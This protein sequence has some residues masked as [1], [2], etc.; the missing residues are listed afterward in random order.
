FKVVDGRSLQRPNEMVLGR[1]AADSYKLTVGDTL[2]LYENRYKIV[3]IYET[4]S[5]FEDAGGALHIREAQNLLS[6]PRSVSFIFVDV[7]DPRQ[8]DT[9]VDAINRRFPEARAT[10]ASEFAQNTNDMQ[11]SAAMMA[12]IRMLAIF[13]GGIVVANTM[14][15][16]I[17]ERTREIGTL[18]AVGW[19]GRRIVG[20]VVE[21]SLLLC[22]LSAV[23]GSIGGVLMMEAMTLIPVFGNILSARWTLA[24]FATAVGVALF[25]GLLGGMWPAWRASRLQPVEALRYE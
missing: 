19:S 14:I 4:G 17:F 10:V 7:V 16:S 1:V 3:G 5:S 6:R 8:A 11:S 20:Q 25:L 21:E 9:V 15:M 24:T 18:R 2:Q 12:A 13:V 22:L 23:L